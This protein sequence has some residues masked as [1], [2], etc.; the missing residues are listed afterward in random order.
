MKT[1]VTELPESRVRVEAVVPPE[2]LAKRVE[3]TARALGRDLRIPGFRKGKVP[4]PVVVRRLGREAVLEETIRTSLGRWYVDAIDES[5]IVPVGDPQLDMQEGAP[6]RGEALTFTIEVGV[7][8]TAELGEY[9]GLEVGRR[10]AAA[11]DEAVEAEVQQLRERLARLETV[12]DAAQTG[13]FDMKTG[14]VSCREIVVISVVAVSLIL[15]LNM[16]V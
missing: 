14:R 10:E 9:K 16:V 4:A 13:D 12:E 7:R 5:G 1:T 6:G 3:Q 8:P 15:N 11:D 2:E